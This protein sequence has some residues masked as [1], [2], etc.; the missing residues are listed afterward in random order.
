MKIHTAES[1][2]LC[3]IIKPVDRGADI[4]NNGGGGGGSVVKLVPVGRG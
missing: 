3:Q 4:G 2:E 1:N